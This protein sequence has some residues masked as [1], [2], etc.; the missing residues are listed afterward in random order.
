MRA[1]EWTSHFKRDYRRVAVGRERT[2]LDTLLRSVLT[3]LA[4]D[5]PLPSHF[6]DHALTG[7]SRDCRD[8]YLKPNLVLIYR[9]PDNATLQLVRLGA[10]NQLG[11]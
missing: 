9:K 11:L 3:R 7:N 10:H 2:S 1:I 4:M 6:R 8:C 5:D